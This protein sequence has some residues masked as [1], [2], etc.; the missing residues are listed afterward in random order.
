MADICQDGNDVVDN[1]I[2][3]KIL[4][5]LRKEMILHGKALLLSFEVFSWGFSNRSI[6]SAYCKIPDSR[7]IKIWKSLKETLGTWN[8]PFSWNQGHL[9]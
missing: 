6:Q 3:M 9:I 5:F 2:V 7:H 1:W 4:S 8:M